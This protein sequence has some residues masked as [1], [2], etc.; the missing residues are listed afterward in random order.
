MKLTQQQQLNATIALDGCIIA[1]PENRPQENRKP[2]A[3]CYLPCNG[4]WEKI[5]RLTIEYGEVTLRYCLRVNEQHYTVIGRWLYLGDRLSVYLVQSEKVRNPYPEVKVLGEQ[6]QLL[7]SPYWQS[8]WKIKN[9]LGLS[10]YPCTVALSGEGES[11]EVEIDIDCDSEKTSD[12]IYAIASKVS[13]YA[14]NFQASLVNLRVGG[15]I[16]DS[17]PPERLL[18][19]ERKRG[20][21]K[22]QSHQGL[23]N[24]LVIPNRKELKNL[25]VSKPNL[26]IVQFDVRKGQIPLP[27][28]GVATGGTISQTS[29]LTT[30]EWEGR[31]MDEE[32][33]LPDGKTVR[34][35][36]QDD[37]QKFS[38]ELLKHGKLQDYSW[39]AQLYT[40]ER[41]EFT[42]DILLITI[43][44]LLDE[45]GIIVE[46]GGL[47][48]A[49]EVRQTVVIG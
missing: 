40:G 11:G 48:R 16:L 30:K 27:G 26:R 10:N 42:G 24:L 1:H 35:W 20:Q 8:Q 39:R 18:T 45:N 34:T 7:I 25:C 31:N 13:E 15:E 46:E 33:R 47:G 5:K 44:P 17:F 12:G 2:F 9:Q 14:L 36:Y 38:G 3:Q 4:Q 43:P 21:V 37:W 32:V 28:K 29:G 22:V 23:E 6:P 49:V 41:C 19:L